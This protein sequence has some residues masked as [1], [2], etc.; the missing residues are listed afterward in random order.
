MERIVSQGG[1]SVPQQVVALADA[2]GN[3]INPPVGVVSSI[4]AGQQLVTSTPTQLPAHALKNG[5]TITACP[6]NKG[7]VLFGA[8]GLTAAYD[9]SGTGDAL[10]PG[11]PRSAACDN[12][13]DV[14]V[15]LASGNTSTTDFVS[16]SGN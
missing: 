13:S 10:Q 15:V 4:Y 6:D 2:A 1:V 9:G 16:F 12:A 7:N 5:L 14:W 8:S 3:P 11:L